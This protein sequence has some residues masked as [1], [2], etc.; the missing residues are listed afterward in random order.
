[1]RRGDPGEG[2]TGNPAAGVL[3]GSF[4]AVVLAGG[5]GTRAGGIDKLTQVVG[6]RTLLAS[7]ISGVV[8]A[9]AAKVILVGP[10]RP[11]LLAS[12]PKP[13]LGFAFVREDPPGSGPVA[14][15]RAGLATVTAPLVAVLAADLPFLRAR[16]LTLL[17]TAMNSSNAGVLVVDESGRR[18]W[19]AGCWRAAALRE[20]LASYDGRSLH[21][22][23]DPLAPVLLHC[24]RAP[25]EPPP[26]L[27]CDTGEDLA[28]AREW[29][30]KLERPHEHS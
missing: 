23:M 30:Q 7:V 13:L 22:L 16:H 28:R 10:R 29:V 15:L 18:Q 17:L 3:A 5:R 4:D 24:P 25:G 6:R 11:G 9:G 1:M 19:L 12:E 27:D 21:G 26:W 2:G 14:A 8:T 20:A